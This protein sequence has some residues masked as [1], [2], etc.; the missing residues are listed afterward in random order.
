[1]TDPAVEVERVQAARVAAR[2]AGLLDGIGEWLGRKMF[3]AVRVDAGA[4]DHARALAEEGT[5]VYVM[6]YRSWLDYLLLAH[7][8]RREGLPAPEY[9][10]G[11]SPWWFRPWRE[12]L[13]DWWWRVRHGHRSREVREHEERERC[14]Q[15]VAAGRPVLVFMRSRT[16]GWGGFGGRRR[17]VAGMRPGSDY[18]RQIVHH[19]W[20]APQEVLLVPV[21]IFRG[22]GM[23]RDARLRTVVYSL[24]DVPTELRRLVALLWNARETSIS[25]GVEVRLR[26]FLQQYQREGEER[27]VR[28]L[29]RALQIFLYREERLVWGPPLIP[30]RQVR[31][32]VL[33][34]GELQDLIQRLAA[35]QG[36]PVASVRQQAERHFEEMA[37]NF[38]GFYFS[39]LEFVFNRVWPRVFQGL[40]Y[41]GLDKVAECVKQHPVVLVPCH[42]SH[43]DYLILSYIFHVNYLSPPHIAAGINLSFWPLGPLFRGAGAYFI[44]RTFEGD[45]LYKMVFRKYLTFLIREGYT[46]EFFI[47]GGRSRT[48][49]ILTPRLGMLAAILDAFVQGVRRD[50]YLVPVS[51]HYGRVVEEEAYQRELAGAEK[52]RESFGTLLRARS[53]L[54]RRHGTVYVTFADPISLD[55]ALGPRRERFHAAAAPA[56]E[57]EKR[58]FVQKLGFRLLRVVNDVTVP[59]ATSVSSTVLLSYPQ[60]ACRRAE[61]V[62]RAVSLT[63]FLQQEGRKL[64]ASLERNLADD[65][66]ESL[67][68]LE[69]GGLI[70]RLATEDEEVIFVPGERRLALDFYKN[71]TIHFFLLPALL[72][73]ALGRGLTGAP[74]L[75]DIGWWL[76]LLRWEFPLPERERLP[77]EMDRLTEYLR[78]VG[79]LRAGGGAAVVA[80]HP[81]VATTRAILDNFREAYWIAAQTLTTLPR[82]GLARKVLLDRMRKRYTT[83][84]LLG[85]VH[86][87]EGNSVV[88]LG[89]AVSRFAE[90]RCIQS[91]AGRGRDPT[92]TP[93]RSFTELSPI[94]ARIRQTM[95]A[96]G[97]RHG[98]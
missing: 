20:H 46:Q 4:V 72:S 88:T 97:A 49:K 86:K 77:A 11:L 40:E 81:F 90:M 75:D 13:A 67:G 95:G 63:E 70:Q 57:E 60:A 79:A 61:F 56:V 10:T 98:A 65:F 85:E 14:Q 22:R 69:H 58:R 24:Q 45:P 55:A 33:S 9:V 48:G 73:E 28:R 5:L 74:L 94:C 64:T 32:R 62:R 54:R 27:I 78:G 92:I 76:E 3:G 51:I 93:G 21:A 12:V 52:V 19:Q 47:E 17:V 41:T 31:Q 7:V 80:D 34:D 8:L 18:L 36:Q 66:R 82:E 44:R 53:A 87:P 23:R 37:A 25:L 35:E 83:G 42:R 29:A 50:L 26:G 6:R 68:F 30:K 15:L 89:N 84:L 59:G 91:A 43:F 71:N 2:R 1:M 96:D 39:I 16:S 38:H